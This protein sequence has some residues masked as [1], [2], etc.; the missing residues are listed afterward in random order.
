MASTFN[1][2]L[3]HL[4][5]IDRFER[6]L[7][8]VRALP[9]GKKFDGRRLS[10]KSDYTKNGLLAEIHK[11]FRPAAASA[12]EIAGRRGFA[13]SASPR[14]IEPHQGMGGI[15]HVT[16]EPDSPPTS[17]GLPICDFGTGT[18]AVQGI[19]AALWEPQRTGVG[20]RVE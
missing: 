14:P 6:A 8:R 1:P 15:M 5:S 7:V 9:M 19:L 2:T 12:V 13:D 11:S 10:S 3:Q 18:W 4:E 20:R 17:V 16:G